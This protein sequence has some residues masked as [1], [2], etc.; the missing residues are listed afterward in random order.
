MREE[1]SSRCHGGDDKGGQD[2]EGKEGDEVEV[3]VGP[4]EHDDELCTNGA[5]VVQRMNADDVGK[6]FDM[7]RASHGGISGEVDRFKP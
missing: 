6:G 4:R 3:E 2:V 1:I 5:D 7:N